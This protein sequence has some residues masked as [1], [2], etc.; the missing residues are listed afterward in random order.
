MRVRTGTAVMSVVYIRFCKVMICTGTA[1][2]TLNQPYQEI[3]PVLVT[4]LCWSNIY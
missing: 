2:F 3:V 1:V 4:G